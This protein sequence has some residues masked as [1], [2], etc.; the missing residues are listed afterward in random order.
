MSINLSPALSGDV[1]S[2]KLFTAR[3]DGA[4][5]SGFRMRKLKASKKT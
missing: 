2:T 3:D 5:N 4:G 1:V